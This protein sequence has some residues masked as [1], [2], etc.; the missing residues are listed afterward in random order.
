LNAVET[1][2]KVSRT[3][4]PG[5]GDSPRRFALRMKRLPARRKASKHTGHIGA[6]VGL[7]PASIAVS[8]R[9]EYDRT[10]AVEIIKTTIEPKR[11]RMNLVGD[12]LLLQHNYDTSLSEVFNRNKNMGAGSVWFHGLADYHKI[13]CRV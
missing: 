5:R 7:I 9:F 4:Q 12:I 10:K 8:T 1:P 11:P 3:H 6:R 2:V 13:V